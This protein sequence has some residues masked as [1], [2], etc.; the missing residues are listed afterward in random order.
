M[1]KSALLFLCI[2]QSLISF[3]QV[4]INEDGSDPDPS[5]ILDLSSLSK[6]FLLPRMSLAEMNSIITP[7]LGLMVFVEDDSS[8]YYYDNTNWKKA[9]SGEQVWVETANGV[10]CIIGSDTIMSILSNGKVGIGT[11]T[12]TNQLSITNAM[13]LT[14]TIDSD[15]GVIYKNGEVFIHDFMVGT[16]Q[17]RNL[18]L[19]GGAGN[20]SL[21][22]SAFYNSSNNTGIGFHSLNA[23][24]EGKENTSVGSLSMEDN[25][26]GY[27][28]TAVGSEALNA[29]TEG[30]WN[31]GIGMWA[32]H[33]NTTGYGNTAI[34]NRALRLNI[35][36]NENA[37]IGNYALEYTTSS[38]NTAFGNNSG[39]NLTTGTHNVV[40][41]A[42]TMY[43]NKT[44]SQNTVIGANAGYGSI[45]QNKSGNTI[46]GTAAGYTSNGSNNIFIGLMAGYNEAGSNKLYIDNSNTATPLIGGDFSSDELYL[47]ADV[48]IGTNSPDPSAALDY[49][50]FKRISRSEAFNN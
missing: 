50:F 23:L 26:S 38:Y 21:S 36:G 34:G 24:T 30:Y 41:G 19:G 39:R 3:S 37:A 8:F 18:F 48:G 20:L 43:W 15:S 9:I 27:Q 42:R 12:P 28:N 16:T 44:G 40:L 6:G 2:I 13:G 46:I 31:T 11:T 49:Q 4:S 5:A 47:Q 45:N 1:K 29:N 17:G 35:S 14:A 32:L 25:T 10:Y 33:L 7:A 22:G